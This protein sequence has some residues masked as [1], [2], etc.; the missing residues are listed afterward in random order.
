MEMSSMNPL[1]GDGG[2]RGWALRGILHI[3]GNFANLIVMLK[4]C[5]APLGQGDGCDFDL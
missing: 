5:V 4:S 3:Y 2:R 1:L